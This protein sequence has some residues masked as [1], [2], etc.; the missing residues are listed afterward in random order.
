MPTISMTDAAVKRL[1]APPGGR[2]EYFDRAVG[3]LVLRVAGPVERPAKGGGIASRPGARSWGLYYRGPGGK[4][5]R[6]TLGRY[7]ALSLADARQSA[8]EALR[9]KEK[10]NDPRTA[11]RAAKE[12]AARQDADTVE[13]VMELFIRRHLETKHRAPS[14]IKTFRAMFENHVLPH[15][16]GRSIASITRKDV[17]HLLDRV[18]DGGTKIRRGGETKVVRGGPIVANRVLA[19]VRVLLGWA[20]RRGMIDSSPAAYV[21]PPGQ[22]RR[23]DRAFSDHEVRMFWA[24]TEG[25]GLLFSRAIPRCLADRPK[26]RRDCRHAMDRSEFR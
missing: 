23:K 16:H 25:T 11:K 17:V 4:L 20:A 10:G 1:A 21:T 2:I 12:E 13:A 19:A 18:T 24:A 3:G 14:Y 15:W 5:I 7:P 22:E 8:T 26:A 6:L 9:G